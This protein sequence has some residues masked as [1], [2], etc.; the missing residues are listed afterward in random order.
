[1]ETV[2]RENVALPAEAAFSLVKDTQDSAT[3]KCVDPPTAHPDV[4]ECLFEVS[5]S[6]GSG[7]YQL[8]H[9]LLRQAAVV[10]SFSL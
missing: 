7:C 9:L 10:E 3:F 8:S 1:L 4:N 2:Y 6:C 5:A